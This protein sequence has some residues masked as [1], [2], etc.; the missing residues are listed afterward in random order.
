MLP[1]WQHSIY[2]R[3]IRIRNLINSVSSIANRGRGAEDSA[4][5]YAAVLDF[6]VSA[7]A[8][9]CEETVVFCIMLYALNIA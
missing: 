6:P 2:N 1:V 3:R 5:L 7:Y 4:R 9:F 8:E